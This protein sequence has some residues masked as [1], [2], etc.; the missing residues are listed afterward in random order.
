MHS[1]SLVFCEEHRND[2]IA[3]AA[4]V[5]IIFVVVFDVD[6]VIGIRCKGVDRER[7]NLKCIQVSLDVGAQ[8]E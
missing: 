7:A 1:K 8:N 2:V 5:V 3:I 6:D 4:V